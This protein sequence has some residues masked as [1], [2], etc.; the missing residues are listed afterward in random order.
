MVA[1]TDPV[2][3]TF[4]PAAGP[5]ASPRDSDLANYALPDPI[6]PRRAPRQGPVFVKARWTYVETT[7]RMRKTIDL[8]LAIQR[9]S[10]TGEWK[11]VEMRAFD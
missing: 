1:D 3:F 2:T 10:D 7:S 9:Q 5:Q 11:V 6:A 4:T 8:Y